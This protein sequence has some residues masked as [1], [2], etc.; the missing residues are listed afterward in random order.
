MSEVKDLA[1]Y[2][3]NPMELG[4]L[5]DAELDALAQ[6]DTGKPEN[7]EPPAVVE[8]EP[9]ADELPEEKA[10]GVAAKDGKHIIPFE[11]LERERSRAAELERIAQDQAAQIEA[12]MQQANGKPNT[13]ETEGV[14]VLTDEQLADISSDLP[15][16]AAIFKA[17]QAQLKQ[18]SESVQTLSAEREARD[19]EMA[20]TSVNEVQNAID[21]NPTLSY[22]QGQDEKTWER[23]VQIDMALRS[24]SEWQSKPIAERFAKVAELYEVAFGRVLPDNKPSQEQLTKQ[25]EERLKAAK[26]KPPVSLGQ[27]PGGS[28]PATDEVTAAMLNKSASELTADFMRMTPAQ[29]EAA[30]ARL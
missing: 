12:L 25:A 6:G 19:A 28:I 5:S 7:N 1:Y 22:L 15:E 9:K 13:G 14:T 4:D 27:I 2:E 21:S 3:A 20:R 10:E 29:I 26:P 16:I 17:Q 30:L 23:A 18:L 11:V 8:D 24:D